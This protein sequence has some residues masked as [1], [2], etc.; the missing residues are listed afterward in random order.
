V[1][2]QASSWHDQRHTKDRNDIEMLS[3]IEDIGDDA[4]SNTRLSG[5]RMLI[6]LLNFH[7][8]WDATGFAS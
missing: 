8:V 6:D 5:K 2:P 3:Q 1:R 4:G 7:E